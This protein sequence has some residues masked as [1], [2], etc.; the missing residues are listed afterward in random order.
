MYGSN[1]PTLYIM[2]QSGSMDKVYE[3]RNYK[4]PGYAV[5]L[6]EDQVRYEGVLEHIKGRGNSSWQLDKKPFNSAI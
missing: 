1:I 4:E 2:T 5:I 6:E 3:D